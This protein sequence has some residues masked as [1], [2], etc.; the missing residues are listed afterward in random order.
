MENEWI[1]WGGGESPVS[2]DALVQWKTRSPDWHFDENAIMR[3][4]DLLW[5]HHDQPYDIIAYRSILAGAA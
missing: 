5:V 3:A 4:D 2:D 1:E